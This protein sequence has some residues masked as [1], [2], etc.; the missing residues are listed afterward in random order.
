MPKTIFLATENSVQ[1]QRIK[2]AL[3]TVMLS[4]TAASIGWWVGYTQGV[5]KVPAAIGVE[6]PN[7]MPTS[8]NPVETPAAVTTSAVVSS[9][10]KTPLQKVRTY[11]PGYN[12][13]MYQHGATISGGANNILV[14]D[15]NMTD[16]D[17]Y[18]GYGYSSWATN[19][20]EPF[21]ITLRDT[22]EIDCIRVLLWSL[23]GRTQRYKLETCSDDET[24]SW[25]TVANHTGPDEKLKGLQTDNFERRAVKQIRLT[26]TFNSANP[27]FYVVELQAS[28]GL[29]SDTQ[30]FEPA[31]DF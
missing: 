20:P 25:T 21:V 10:S 24:R 27:S 9:T 17:Y 18:K 1:R 19:P 23:D 22:V 14:I 31:P 30:H 29:P 13:A 6:Q 8:P 3:V 11:P 7:I 5:A 16:Y 15:G 28:L 12:F 26:G 2:I 4:L